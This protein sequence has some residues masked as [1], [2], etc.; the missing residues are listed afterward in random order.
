MGG[1]LKVDGVLVGF[2]TKSEPASMLAEVLDSLIEFGCTVL[3]CATRSKDRTKRRG[4]LR[5]VRNLRAR[6]WLVRWVDK[7]RDWPNEEEQGNRKC[8]A[9]TIREILA[10]VKRALPAKGRQRILTAAC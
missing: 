4:S 8:A 9:K 3:V 2:M 7:H 10:A 1:V 6:G 5:V